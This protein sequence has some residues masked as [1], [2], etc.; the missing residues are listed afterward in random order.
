[1]IIGIIL[2][3]LVWIYILLVFKKNT[4][5][6]FFFI[7]GSLGSFTILFGLFYKTFVDVL[8]V[9][10]LSIL[11]KISII[12]PIYEVFIKYNIIFINYEDTAISLFMDYECSG[13]IEILALISIV[14][15]YPLFKFRTK[16]FN[17]IIGFFWIC[18][19]NVIRLFTIAVIL[20]NFGNDYYY[21]AHSI[22]GRLIFYLFTMILYF[23]M[24]SYQQIKTQNIGKFNYNTKEN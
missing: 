23:Y 18:L 7:V 22:V 15:F 16:I 17:I 24:F 20:Y 4:L 12:C 5:S 9:F 19:A 14:S 3:I 8:S 21:V 1:M 11:D 10:I 6:A 13:L 2:L